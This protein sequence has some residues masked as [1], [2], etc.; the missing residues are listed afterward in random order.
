MDNIAERVRIIG[1]TPISTVEKMKAAMDIDETN[2][3][4]LGSNEMLD[5]LLFSHMKIQT[6][7][8]EVITN[9]KLFENDPGTEDF[10]VGLL[11]KHES[12]SWM[13]KSHLD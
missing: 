9:D 7:L 4:A 1:E 11:Q 13:L 6:H 5:D 8:K 2:G 12:M 10:L 3:E